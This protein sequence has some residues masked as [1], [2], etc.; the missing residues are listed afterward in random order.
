MDPA[1]KVVHAWKELRVRVKAEVRA[2]EGERRWREAAA[3]L[4][5]ADSGGC[6]SDIFES[7]GVG[8]EEGLELDGSKKVTMGAEEAEGDEVG[9]AGGETAEEGRVAAMEE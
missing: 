1:P 7:L 9:K 5:P 3:P 6:S 2:G 8:K 4:T